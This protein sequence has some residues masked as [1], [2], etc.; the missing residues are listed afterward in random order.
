MSIGFCLFY[1]DWL[2]EPSSQP[3]TVNPIATPVMA[4]QVPRYN[5]SLT[6]KSSIRSSRVHL[7]LHRIHLAA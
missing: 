1:S 4:S 5:M 7:R 6:L 3:S 2:S